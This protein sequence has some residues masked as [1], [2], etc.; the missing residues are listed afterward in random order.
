MNKKD[1]ILVLGCGVRLNK[2]S[3]NYYFMFVLE[4]NGYFTAV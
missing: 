4:N 2:K 1:G 3:I